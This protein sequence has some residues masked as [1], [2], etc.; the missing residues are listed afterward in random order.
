M[1][2]LPLAPQKREE[3]QAPDYREAWEYYHTPRAQHPNASSVVPVH[4]LAL[5]VAYDAFHLAEQLLISS[6]VLWNA[7]A[8]YP[9]SGVSFGKP[10]SPSKNLSHARSGTSADPKLPV[11]TG[12]RELPGFWLPAG[13]SEPPNADAET[14][15]LTCSGVPE[16][17]RAN[18]LPIA[19]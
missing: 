17:A 12:R 7:T 8:T 5:L 14:T 9:S 10:M 19:L 15:R 3:G 13:K 2:M 18:Y 6:A 16:G 1:A 4:S 11:S